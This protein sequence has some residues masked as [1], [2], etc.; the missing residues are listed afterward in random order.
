MIKEIII[1]DLK[2]TWKKLG[3]EYSDKYYVEVPKNQEYG[4]FSTNAALVNARNNSINSKDMAKQ[5][6]NYLAKKKHY[7]SV[8]VAGNGFI[9]FEIAN[10]L[11]Y[12]ALKEISSQG[13]SYGASNFGD[14]RKALIEFVSANPTGPL[15]VVNA[16]AAAFGDVLF[17]IMNYAG[18]Q[19]KREFYINDAGNQVDVLAESLEMR[20][21]EVIGEQIEELPPGTYQGTYIIDLA[22]K[23]KAKEGS[24]I[25]HYSEADKLEKMKEFALEEIHQMQRDS[26]ER[27]GVEFDSWVSEKILRSQGVIEEVL[28]YLAEADCTYESEDAIWFASSKFGDEKDRVLMKSDGEIT[29]FVPDLAYHL[30]K[31]HRGFD[32]MIDVLG[33]DHH[34]YVPRLRAAIRALNFDESKLEIVFLQQVNLYESGEKIKMS[35]RTG[36]IVTMDELV[37]E[38]GVDAARFFFLEK[39]PSAHLNFDLELA[40]KK[41]SENP[42]Y[43]CQYAHARIC[44]VL[45]KA[46]K[47][48]ISLKKFDENEL[49][50]LK[51]DEEMVIIKKL[52]DFPDLIAAIAEFREPHRLAFYVYD[53]AALFHKYYQKYQIVDSNNLELSRARLY[54]ISAIKDVLA[55]SFQLMGISAPE[56]MTKKDTSDKGKGK[57][58][59]A[60]KEKEVSDSTAKILEDVAKKKGKIS[61][62]KEKPTS[63]PI[64]KPKKIAAPKP[65]PEDKSKKIEK[66][67]KSLEKKTPL[68]KDKYKDKDIKTKTE[69]KTSSK[70]TVSKIEKK[71]IAKEAKK[72]NSK[73]KEHVAKVDK[74]KVLLAKKEPAKRKITK[75]QPKKKKS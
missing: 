23:L 35:K 43:Y 40:K 48:K 49:K 53:L 36:N 29:Y 12:K 21:R 30:T 1:K 64:E 28:S 56:S 4:D 61:P 9:N 71:D 42:V 26:L 66:V 69:T 41:T 60:P 37:E 45:R 14:G 63:P 52:L 17:R 34:G 72:Q 24:K 74:K 15:N 22:L 65:K 33:P 32:Y 51:Q 58:K 3:F 20:Y 11:Y 10:N 67:E 19:A 8:K 57:K 68:V 7:K 70:R 38:V 39:K 13:K 44:S 46:K 62:Q 59:A 25:M 2:E 18:F 55:I 54:L 75:I 5:I 47:E 31:Y 16:R 6:A 73:P 27:F 50:K